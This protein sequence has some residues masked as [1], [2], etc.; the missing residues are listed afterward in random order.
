M[1]QNSW[2]KIALASFVIIF[3]TIYALPNLYPDEP[4]IQIS[5]ASASIEA[6][7]DVA[8]QAEQAIAEAK[9]PYKPHERVDTSMLIRIGDSE[10]QIKAKEIAQAAVGDR[11]VVALNLAPTT[12]RWL[13]LLG[14]HPMKLGLDLRGGVHFMLEV[15]MQ[16]AVAQREDT[17]VDQ[18]RQALRE[19]L[20]E[21]QRY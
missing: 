14:A 2:W 17:W 8:R 11:Y 18:F 21:G 10:A 1:N 12:P 19:K 6:T 4:A 13:R 3:S 15:D 16:K 20:P 5:G 9:L 7:D